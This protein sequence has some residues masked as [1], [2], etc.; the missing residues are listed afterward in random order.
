MRRPCLAN[1]LGGQ[2]V[3][4]A[5][6]KLSAAGI[7]SFRYPDSAARVFAY[8]WKY[9]QN[10]RNLYE[11]PALPA[12]AGSMLSTSQ[13]RL[14]PIKSA[15]A[16]GR[17]H[18][19]Q[20]EVTHLF[21]EFRIP[22]PATRVALNEEEVRKLWP[23]AGRELRLCSL[24][25][26]ELGPILVFGSVDPLTHEL[27]DFVVGLPPLNATLAKRMLEQTEVY[28]SLQRLAGGKMAE[29][30][31]LQLFLVRF[32]QLIAEAERIKEARLTLW[33]TATNSIAVED[34]S[35][36]LHPPDLTEHD[37]PRPA[38]RPYPLQ[39]VSHW[40]LPEDI[41]ITV[42][43]ICPEDEPAMVAFHGT[44]SDRSVYF[45]YFGTLNLQRRVEHERLA[46]LCFVDYDREIA[47]VADRFESNR[48][49]ILGV[50]RLIKSRFATEGEFAVVVSD[51]HQGRGLGCYLLGQLI[52][53]A[54]GEKLERL[55]GLILRENNAMLR[56]CRKLGFQVAYDDREQL[57]R[58]GLRL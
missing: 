42:R 4:K 40:K 28:R 9:G 20:A 36:V 56:V 5:R 43:P 44:L 53:V 55:T 45:R 15:H 6:A 17:T 23:S 32:S 49:R 16:D 38:I 26:A 51:Q 22:E 2:R 30:E 25:D 37:L 3:A 24:V 7:P 10:L 13:D 50:A 57:Y 46:R 11:T 21:S 29:V 8:I 52:E 41:E 27:D 39:Y 34:A 48:H 58:A 54:A 35:I 33:L 31:T 19:T 14:E 47:L 12:A 1:W 18:L